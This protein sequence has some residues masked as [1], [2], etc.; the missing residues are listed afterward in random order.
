MSASPPYQSACPGCRRENGKLTTVYGRDPRL[1]SS[2]FD[3]TVLLA[4]MQGPVWVLDL[5]AQEHGVLRGP[6]VS[7]VGRRSP[8]LARNAII[9]QI[10]GS[11]ARCALGGR[12]TKTVCSCDYLWRFATLERDSGRDS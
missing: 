6:I 11:R 10:V 1:R 8:G 5:G 4:G 7:G 12:L 2:Y 3:E 9:W